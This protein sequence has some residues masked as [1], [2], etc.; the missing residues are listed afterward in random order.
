VDSELPLQFDLPR[1]FQWAF[2]LATLPYLAVGL[3]IGPAILLSRGRYTVGVAAVG[4]V[5]ALLG[6]LVLQHLRYAKCV[7]IAAADLEVTSIGGRQVSGSLHDVR[8]RTLNHPRA[9]EGIVTLAISCSGV[10]ADGKEVVINHRFPGFVAIMDRLIQEGCVIESRD[11]KWWERLS[12]T[13]W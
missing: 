13:G 5:L 1:R 12:Y 4:V 2:W 8:I 11:P 7:L 3:S 6:A 9:R 10:Q